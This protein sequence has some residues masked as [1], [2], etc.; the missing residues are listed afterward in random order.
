MCTDGFSAKKNGQ[1]AAESFHALQ[2]SNPCRPTHCDSPKPL[3]HELVSIYRKKG[4]WLVIFRNLEPI[5]ACRI[6]ILA[7]LR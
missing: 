7:L 4:I 2:E 6:V 5:F 1:G 3:S